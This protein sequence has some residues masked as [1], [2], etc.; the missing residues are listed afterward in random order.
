MRFVKYV[1]NERNK[2]NEKKKK[3]KVQLSDKISRKNLR[4]FDPDMIALDF[5]STNI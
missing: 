1:S 5:P 3:R 4:L 2:G